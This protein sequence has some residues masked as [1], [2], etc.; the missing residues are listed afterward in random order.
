MKLVSPIKSVRFA[1]VVERCG[2]PVLHVSWLPP[3]KDKELQAAEKQ[4][5]VMTLHQHVRGA[6]KDFGTVGLDLKQADTPQ[7]LIFPKSLRAFAGQKIIAINYALLG[8][9]KEARGGMVDLSKTRAKAVEPARPA[10]TLRVVDDEPESAPRRDKVRTRSRPD[11][12]RVEPK[13]G[14][15]RAKVRT[16]S[17]PSA[18]RPKPTAAPKPD[19]VRLDP[20]LVADL[21]AA[22]NELKSGKQVAAHERLQTLLARI[23]S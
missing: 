12:E 16:G 2:A 23:E 21:R 8:A 11:E 13:S 22:V 3:A 9:E 14:T 15:S 4:Q 18:A 7:I 17:R 1:T 10:P 20:E 19:K 5:R 6:K